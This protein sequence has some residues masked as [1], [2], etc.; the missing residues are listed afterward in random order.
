LNFLSVGADALLIEM[1]PCPQ[2]AW[3][4]ADQALTPFEFASLMDRLDAIARAT[5]RSVDRRDVAESVAA[6]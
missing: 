1:H 5:G 3:C 6:A 4:D 2:E